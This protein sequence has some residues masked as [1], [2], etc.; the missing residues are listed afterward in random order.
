[1]HHELSEEFLIKQRD[2]ERIMKGVIITVAGISS[3][4][5]AG[6]P[7]EKKQLKAI[8]TEGEQKSTLLYQLLKKCSY[9]DQVIIVGGYK[10]EDLKQYC[11]GLEQDYQDRITLVFNEHYEDLN[12]G[13]SLYLGLQEAFSKDVDEILFVEGDLDIDAQSFAQVI[14]AKKSV[15]TYTSE[16]IYANKAVVL[17]QDKN[18]CF[19]YA[20]NSAHGLLTINEPFSCILNSG[21]TWKF[22]DM[23]AMR[24]ANTDFGELEK[25]G[26]N[27]RIIQRYI[28]ARP[29]NEIELVK[30][31]RWTNCNTKDDYRKIAHYWRNEN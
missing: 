19:R 14:E 21:Q 17:Y 2:N 10:F 7:E 1:M 9:A 29:V 24:R 16:P 18:G 30:L 4:F 8:Y 20:F 11:E 23:V 28:E 31:E 27:L 26:T 12:S 3:R 22:T 5:N 6:V 25:D 15:L 13:Y